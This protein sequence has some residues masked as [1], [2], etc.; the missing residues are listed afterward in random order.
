MML[1]E[2]Y[3]FTYIPSIDQIFRSQYNIQI[4]LDLINAFLLKNKVLDEDLTEAERTQAYE[5]VT[6]KLE[7]TKDVDLDVRWFFWP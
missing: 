5:H 3:I 4:T 2:F 6:S 7:K 1:V